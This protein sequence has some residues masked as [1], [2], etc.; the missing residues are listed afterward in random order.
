[1][2]SIN[3]NVLSGYIL[4]EGGDNYIKFENSGLPIKSDPQDLFRRF[5]K[6][7]PTSESPG[8]GLSIVNTICQQN[9]IKIEY[10]YKNGNH[11]IILQF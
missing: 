10:T 2:N 5:K 9:G 3:Y 8:L 6:G 4:I 11:K 1:M 7:D